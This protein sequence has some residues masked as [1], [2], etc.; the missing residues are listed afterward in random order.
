MENAADALKI[1]IGIF[2]FSIGIFILFNMTSQAKEAARVLIAENDSTKY[3]NYYEDATEDQIDGNGNR[4]VTFDE[5][6]PV[7][8]RYFQENYGVTI[9]DKYG[10]IMGRFDADTE[11]ICNRWTTESAESKREFIVKTQTVYNKVNILAEKLNGTEVIFYDDVLNKEPDY[12]VE[13]DGTIDYID[14]PGDNN[15][16]TYKDF[17]NNINVSYTNEC[18]MYTYFSEWYAVNM[19]PGYT[20]LHNPN[21]YWTGDS[22]QK[23]A[24][25]V[26]SDISR[27]K[28]IFQYN[29][30]RYTGGGYI[31]NVR[32]SYS[33]STRWIS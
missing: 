11:N 32:K 23:R 1:V 13:R 25:R 7:L 26:D 12:K 14:S 27:N 15:T 33:L 5:I 22:N 9:V 17:F 3:Y 16:L 19:I 20:G 10:K 21:C 18:L 29:K 31:G 4:I 6:V 28:C 8:Y 24:Q 2:I 30:S